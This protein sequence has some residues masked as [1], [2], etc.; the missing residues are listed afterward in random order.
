[1][2]KAFMVGRAT[3][4][5]ELKV[6]PSGVNVGEF[7]LAV[8]R[9]FGKKK[10][11]DFIRCA[12]FGNAAENVKNYVK[13]GDVIS[14]VGEIMCNAWQGKNGEVSSQLSIYVS[15][16]RIKAHAQKSDGAKKSEQLSFDDFLEVNEK[17]IPF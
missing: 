11:T 13:K 4:D 7:T 10:Q 12:V 5:G 15:E 3:K 6:T 8:D 9:G 17:N 14:V 16:L 2:N 1:M